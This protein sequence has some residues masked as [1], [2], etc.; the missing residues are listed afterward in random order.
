MQRHPWILNKA[1]SV[2]LIIDVQEKFRSAMRNPEELAA[3]INTMI[4]GAKILGVPIVVTE[5]YPKGLGKTFEDITAH[6]EEHQYFEK[7]CFSACGAPDL[8]SWLSQTGRRQV[9]V[10]GIEAHICVNQTSHDLIHNG[11]DVH[12][13]TDA[14]ASRSPENKEIGLR[15]M[16]AAGAVMSCV[17]MA[18]FEMLVESGNE[19]FKAVQ[20]LVK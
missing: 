19:T 16:H 1:N 2:L 8:M 3:K 5:Q 6:L 18:L 9:M 11:F 17:E 4:D 12:L 14:V 7:D 15:K 10:C 20:R 13:I